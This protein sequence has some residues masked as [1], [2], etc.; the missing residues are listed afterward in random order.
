LELRSQTTGPSDEYRGIVSTE[1][2]TGNPLKGA[3]ERMARRRYQKGQLILKGKRQ[4]VWI[5]RWREDVLQ[6]DGTRHRQR[7]SERMGTLKEYP[8]RR[9][10]ERALERLIA[11]AGVNSLDYQA[12]PTASFAEFAAKWQF[13]VL[14]QHKPSTQSADGSR[15]KRHLIPDLGETLMRDINAQRL[16]AFVATKARTVSPKSVKNLVA[17]LR[18]MWNQAR[19]WG[20]VQHDA[21]LGLVLPESSP[22]NERCLSLEEMRTIIAAAEEPYKTYY[23]ILAETGMRAGEIGA[24]TTGNVLLDHGVIKISQGVW[25]GKIQTVKSK[26]GNRICEISKQ[27]AEHLRK[28]ILASNSNPSGLLFCTSNG[29][30]WDAD[31]LRKR[32]F[33][34]LLKKLNIA[35]CGFHAFRHGNATL[36]DQKQVPIATRQNRLGQSDARTTMGY[37]HAVSQDG[38]R[39]AEEIGSSLVA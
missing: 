18:M 9:L 37:T 36:M 39:F 24:L 32:R 38:R 11:R 5:G 31:T 3:C 27:L 29:T 12:R 8:T 7:R 1:A 6:P 4:K 16:Q 21:F 20:Y 30:P 33:H 2:N 34:P 13:D 23:W 22:L 10:A 28:Y 35:P 25:H 14:S 19:A 26:K 17:L 15:I